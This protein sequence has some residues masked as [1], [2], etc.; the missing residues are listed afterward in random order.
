MTP[1]PRVT[2][3]LP[4]HN[5]EVFLHHCLDSLLAQTYR[6]FELLIFDNASTD[7]TEQICREYMAND[8]RINYKRNERNIGIV[9]NFNAAFQFAQGEFFRWA[10][11]D[12]ICAPE[13]L[14]RLVERLDRRPE[15]VLC[16]AKT[17]LIDERGKFV[18]E[19]E[20]GLNLPYPS[21][22]RRFLQVLGYIRMVNV[23]YGLMRSHFLRMT[24]L[25]GNY[26]SSD[27]VFLGHLS[28][29]GPFEEIA[30]PLFF[31]RVHAEMTIQKYPSAHQRA[32]WMDPSLKGKLIFPNWRFLFGYLRAIER[33]PIG[34]KEKFRCLVRMRYWIKR[35][36]SGL[37]EDLRM[38]AMHP[39]GYPS[40]T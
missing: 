23:T 19:Y 9:P 17:H 37:W 15:L 35:W 22:S 26:P 30:E 38:A 11:A 20:D 10:A 21:P 7:R 34:L 2:V 14:E 18:R 16:Y 6:E 31:R 4:V 36:G 33:A 40:G 28:L 39:F 8:S 13:M 27:L 25:F 24:D 12:D 1:Q 3:A 29:L 5:G 32:I